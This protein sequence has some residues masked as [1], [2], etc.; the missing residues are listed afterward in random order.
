MALIVLVAQDAFE[1]ILLARRVTRRLL[2]ARL[3]YRATRC[4][5]TPIGRLIH[6]GGKLREFFLLGNGCARRGYA[7][8]STA[9]R[10][11]GAMHRRRRTQMPIPTLPFGRL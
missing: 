5:W 1:T 2:L 3:F 7:R 6:R 9:L 11:P 8:E 4:G 10:H